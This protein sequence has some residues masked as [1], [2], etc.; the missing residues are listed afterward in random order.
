MHERLI[1]SEDKSDALSI[2]LSGGNR[3]CVRAV[4]VNGEQYEAG[5]NRSNS[6]IVVIGVTPK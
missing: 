6:Q 2:V 5:K 1:V 4:S 3:R